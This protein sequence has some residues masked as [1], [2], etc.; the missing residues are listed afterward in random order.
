MKGQ[1]DA[2]GEFAGKLASQVFFQLM[3]VPQDAW[4]LV[5]NWV[6]TALDG[7]RATMLPQLRAK[8]GTTTF[9][10]RAYFRALQDGA[11]KTAPNS[12]LAGMQA[13]TGCPAS[14][15]KMDPDEAMNTAV[16]MALGGYLS[17]EFLIGTG[18]YNLLRHPDQWQQLLHNRSLMPRAIDEMLRY[19]APF[20]LAD[21]WV[22]DRNEKGD[23]IEAI[24]LGGEKLKS[25]TVIA[26][27]YGS[28]NRDET[29]FDKPEEFN[30][31]RNLRKGAEDPTPNLGFGDGVHRCI[32]ESLAR[33]VTAAAIGALLDLAPTARIGEVG[34]WAADPYFRS[35]TRLQLL[36]R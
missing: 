32:G 25:G 6:R 34:P 17:T 4:D 12:I 10:M 3:G 5:D 29:V 19:D 28:A 15:V 30:I 23:A 16:H 14:H 13:A 7:H 31:T 33:P 11:S 8:G 20:Q 21:R 9:A 35:L 27:V 24:E 36:L 26:V 18:V 22:N 1:V 2:I